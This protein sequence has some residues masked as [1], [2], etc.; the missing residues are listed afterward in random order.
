M[1]DELTEQMVLNLAL[2][3][4]NQLKLPSWMMED[5][6]H[7]L[8]ARLRLGKGL[9]WDGITDSEHRKA[10]RTRYLKWRLKDSARHRLT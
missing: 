8:W 3:V 6:A 1:S 7:D 2:K 5:D 4:Y 9:P 10:F